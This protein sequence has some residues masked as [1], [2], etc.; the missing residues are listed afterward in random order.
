MGY[1]LLC[2]LAAV[3]VWAQPA[4]FEGT[5]QGTLSGHGTKLRLGLHIEKTSSGGYATKMDSIDQGAIGIPVKDTTISGQQLTIELPEL[6]VKFVGTLSADGSEIAGTYTRGLERPL[7]FKRVAKIE[8]LER[9]QTPKPPFPYKAEE[10]TYENKVAGVKLAGTL[11]VPNGAGPFPAAILITG[12]GV[13]DRDES[14][15]GHQP[16]WILADYLSRHGIAVLRSDDRG[17]GG[18]TGDKMA[19]DL[20]NLAGD[21]VAATAFLKARKEI[22]AKHIGVIGHSEGGILGP[23]AATQSADISFVVMMAGTG[24]PGEQIILRQIEASARAQGAPADAIGQMLDRQRNLMS[25]V[26]DSDAATAAEKLKAAGLQPPQIA[27]VNSVHLRSFL[28]LDPAPVLAKVK[29]PVLAVNGAKDLQVSPEQNLGAIRMALSGN[30]NA[31]VTELPGLNHLF[32]TCHD[33]TVTEYAGIQETLAPSV[34]ELISNWV[35]Q[36]TR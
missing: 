26:K 7:T 4:G 13:H 9:P 23:L 14:I 2:L 22:A 1:I 17:V 11:T 27:S 5:W 16:F 18:S 6:S 29:V 10:V 35:T 34:L 19:A 33:C 25:I 24:V 15:V 31:T 32:Q 3:S 12:S 28:V 21:V 36:H 20:P 30:S 8:E